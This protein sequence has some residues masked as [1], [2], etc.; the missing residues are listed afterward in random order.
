VKHSSGGDEV[1]LKEMDTALRQLC[2]S[3]IAGY[4]VPD[5]ILV[6]GQWI[7]CV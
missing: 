2:K 6:S 3:K 1:N 5:F 4:A 7:N